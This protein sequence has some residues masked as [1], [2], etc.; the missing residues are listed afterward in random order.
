MTIMK[1]NLFLLLVIAAIFVT[2]CGDFHKTI[3]IPRA[4]LQSLINKNFPIDKNIIIARLTIDTPSVYFKDQNVGIKMNY[5]G[6]FFADEIKGYMDVNGRIT[7]KQER[8]AF[9]LTD[10]NIEEFEVNGL[11][12]SNTE[13]IKHVLQNIAN[14]F[15]EG[16]PIYNLNQKNFR[17]K[18]A[19]IFLKKLTI[20]EETL[21]IQ[22][23]S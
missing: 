3:V 12:F 2:G 9:Y 22:L 1:K 17:Q 13:K 20:K 15:L 8:A 16:Y 14:N 4:K 21:E 19:K 7:Y 10:I 11:N 6:N 23:G 5:K 18:V